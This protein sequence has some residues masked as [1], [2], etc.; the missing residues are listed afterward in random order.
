MANIC[1]NWV[2][3]TGDEADIDKVRKLVGEEFDFNKIIPLESGTA[4]QAREN[5]GCNS[6]AFDPE[7]DDEGCVLEWYFWTKWCPPEPIYDKLCELF[8]D[9][10]IYWRYEESGC[11]LYGFFND[12]E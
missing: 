4:K 10:H 8:P 11:G 6:I 5:W 9:V 12:Q 3:I 2:R 7:F 1:S